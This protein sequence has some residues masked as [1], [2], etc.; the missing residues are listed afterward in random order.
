MAIVLLLLSS[1][2]DEARESASYRSGRPAT[3]ADNNLWFICSVFPMAI[4]VAS[5]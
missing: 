4:E 5:L 1:W 3:W 2:R